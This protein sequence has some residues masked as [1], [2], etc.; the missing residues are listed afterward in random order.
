MQK[1]SRLKVALV[2]SR[3][4]AYDVARE[5]GVS[6][7]R[8]SRIVNGRILPTPDEA[9]RLARALGIPVAEIATRRAA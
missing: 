9:A 2:E 3:R 6:E 8:L 7:T 1:V 5:V 4:F